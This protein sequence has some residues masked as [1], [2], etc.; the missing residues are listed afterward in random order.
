LDRISQR[1]GVS[2]DN[3]QNVDKGTQIL[4]AIRYRELAARGEMLSF[5][6][7]GF[8]NYSQTT[9]D[10]ILHYIFSL[11]GV[12]N[13]KAVEFCAGSGDQSNS[14]NLIINH[15]WFA[16][17][18][19]GGKENVAR[20][21]QFFASLA[22][23]DVMGPVYLHHWVT[24][25]S[26]NTLLEQHGFS[27]EIDLLSLD[28]DGVDY[29]IWEA[30]TAASPRVVVVE[31][32]PQL[33]GRS[34][35]V[36]CGDDFQAQWIKLPKGEELSG[37]RGFFSTMTLYGGASLPAFNKLAKRKGY[38][39]VG[40][41]DIGFNVVFMRHDIGAD[42]FPEVSEESCVNPAYRERFART[43]EALKDF[44]WREV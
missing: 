4:L 29:W 38:R 33:G 26:V 12:T 22:G 41:N 23:T 18:V 7:V 6:E 31:A 5:S 15:G 30:L 14:A 9:E 11:A 37:D 19:D 21:R 36:P 42:L 1:F 8:R 25:D 24:R 44:E 10:G 32:M 16:L 43:W 3:F 28:M 40:A 27:G 20:G 39:L 34:I 17:M 2:I 35:T 13:R